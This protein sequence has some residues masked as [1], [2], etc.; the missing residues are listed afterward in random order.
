MVNKKI[1]RKIPKNFTII[2]VTK[3]RFYKKIYL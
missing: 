2:L 3:K 1:M